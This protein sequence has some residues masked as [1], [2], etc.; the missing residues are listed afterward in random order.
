MNIE[1]EITRACNFKCIHC[2]A[3]AGRPRKN[4]FTIEELI[5]VLQQ[6][7]E[8][9][10]KIVVTGGEP[11]V[12]KDV[13]LI[14]VKIKEFGF[15]IIF[16]TNTYLLN[17]E[18][19]KKLKDLKIEH[20][21]TSIYGSNALIHEEITGIKGSFDR[22]CQN[23][24]LMKQAG[25]RVSIAA[26]VNK[27]NLKDLE[28]MARLLKKLEVTGS[29]SRI[30]MGGRAKEHEKEL[31]ISPIEYQNYIQKIYEIQKKYENIG[32]GYLKNNETFS[33]LVNKTAG[34]KRCDA[35]T[36]NIGIRSDLK[37]TPCLALHPVVIGDLRKQGLKKILGS[38]EI[39]F[40]SDFNEASVKCSRC[41]YSSMCKGGC[42][43]HAFY[44]TG[45]IE[46]RDPGC[47]L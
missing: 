31:S 12:R 25:I 19:I 28:S 8:K 39:R 7:K 23:V 4:E 35:G 15:E 22:L 36:E 27:K 20:I 45:N 41:N 21:R 26:V 17:P 11:L 37:V 38:K 1:L 32:F 13:F 33:F 42:R 47:W 14:L 46:A 5:P 43:A 10:K 29:F 30:I 2:I 6:T 3:D 44:G 9:F 24:K 40:F 34:Y 16:N 18:K